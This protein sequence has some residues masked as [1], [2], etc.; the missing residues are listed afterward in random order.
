MVHLAMMLKTVAV[1]GL[2]VYDNVVQSILE[3]C[4]LFVFEA[5]RLLFDDQ[6]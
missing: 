6:N 5:I 4:F 1:N 2:L 3:R